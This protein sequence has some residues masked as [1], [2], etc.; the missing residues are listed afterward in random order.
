MIGNGFHGNTNHPHQPAAACSLRPG[1]SS[2]EV[3]EFRD[4]FLE[5]DE[6]F[7]VG[8]LGLSDGELEG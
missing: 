4:L 2:S 7:G 6:G 3:Q 1:F 5:S 8:A